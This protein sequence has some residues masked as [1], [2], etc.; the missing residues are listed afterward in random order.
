MRKKKALIN[1]AFS[2]LLEV[3]T[4][5]TGFILP[6]LF[7]GTFGS[8][9]NGLIS[10]IASFIGYITLLQSGVG[11]VAKAAMY[12]PLAEKD[13]NKICVIVKTLESFFRKIAVITVAYIFVLAILF[14]TLIAPEA[15]SF[16]FTFSLVIIIGVS[17][18]A[19][20][21]FGI[22]H[23][24]LLEADQRS[25][26][27]SSIQIATVIINTLVSVLLIG[28]GC[29]IQ[30]VKLGSA[31]IFVLRPITLSLYSR[32]KF[33]IIADVPTDNTLIKQRWDGFAQAIAYFIHS[34]TDIFVL[35]I[36]ARLS[37]A[38][39]LGLVSVYSVYNMVTYGLNSFV[40][41]IERAV[42]SALGNIIAL[43]ERE[44]LTKT[45]NT[46]NT[47]M[48]IVCT[49]IF[50]TACITIFK[51]VEIYVNNVADINYIQYIFG[52]I[53]IT[54]E[55]F[56][57]LRS[58]YNSIIYAAGKFKETKTSA[59][60]EAGINIIASIILVYKF[61]LVGV[62]VGT[63]TAMLYR[64][65]SFIRFLNR[66]VLFLGIWKQIKRYL[67]S[68]TNYVLLIVLGSKIH[69]QIGDLFAWLIYAGVVFL[70]TGLFTVF[71]NYLLMK[72]ETIAVIR[73]FI[74]KRSN[75]K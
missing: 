45:F 66:E 65:V 39:S 71:F 67:V 75:E 46:Y 12:K 40:R 8:E 69:L 16:L 47:F 21:F 35:T 10:S 42:T 33:S 56:Y 29:S 43:D 24:M 23:Q 36:F 70:T 59:W 50:S 52:Y 51:F 26:V 41:T 34:K 31:I 4:V 55:Y 2:M 27:Y 28:I 15:G 13:H 48:H 37:P 7:I 73:T 72:H 6:R 44:H 63:L 25:Y 57:C 30:I 19:Q 32:K 9:V 68:L 18:A 1:T 49:S 5:I 53:I 14:P 3:V 60:I 17:T 54:A 58:P 61:G 62:A 20:Y 38:V 22:T 64:T 74:W 11:S